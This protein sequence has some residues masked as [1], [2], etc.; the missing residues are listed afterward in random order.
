MSYTIPSDTH[1]V[2]DTGHTT[3]HNN[4]T[5]VLSGMNAASS[6]HNTAYAGGAKGDGTTDDAAAIQAAL[7]AC[8]P[9]GI[10]WL[11]AL[12]YR[13]G[14]ELTVPP[15]VT[16]AGLHGNRTDNVQLSATIKPLASFSGTGCLR[17]KDKE[18]G[19]YSADNNG[20]RVVNLVL[21][22]SATTGSVEGIRATG[23]VHGVVLD[24]VAV[25]QFASYGVG[26]H[27][28]TRLDA[29]VQHPYSW[30]LWNCMAWQNK[31]HG[32]FF[33]NQQ[34]D[35]TFLN[36][37]A[38]GNVG[39]GFYLLA[40]QN[41]QCVACRSEFNLNGFNLQGSWGTTTASGGMLI[42]GC[43]T[44]RNTQHGVRIE[45]SGNGVHTISVS[46]R[47]DGRNSN[48]GGGGF[49]GIKV[50]GAA[51][52]V[53][54]TGLS[55]YPGVDDDGSGTSS[56][57]YGLSVVNSPTFVH[58]GNAFLHA[59]VA[60]VNWDGTGTFVTRGVSTRTGST[61]SP[62]AIDF[63]GD[64]GDAGNVFGTGADGAAT[65]DGAATA[66]WASL[67]A[68]V[69]TMT[70]DAHLTALTVNNGVTLKTANFR[71][72]CQ[73]LL[74]NAGT[75]SNLGNNASGSTAGASGGSAVYTGG[76]AGGA[77]GTGVSG[78]GGAGAG[79][80]MGASAG[81]GG[82]GTSGAAGTAG[83][84]A[85]GVT[86]AIAQNNF[87]QTPYPV[88]AGAT[89]FNNAAVLFGWGAAGGGGG[90]DASSN[91]G[92]GGGG[93]GGIVPL[94]A[95]YITNTGTISANGGNGG[96]AAGG[97]AGGGG[98]GAGGLLAAFTLVPWTQ[99]GTATA[100][101]GTHGNKAGTGSNGVDGG[102][103][104]VLNVVMG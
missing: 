64:Q 36:C 33:G 93:G 44:D 95:W 69:Y 51:T 4:L 89:A 86:A 82:A 73:G 54:I 74:T 25:Q 67:A 101:G 65:L 6:V 48:S 21:D 20:I 47:R 60:G 91:A 8:P 55:C 104:L 97:N 30:N 29:S 63:Q 102:A 45:S 11:R 76:R 61:S 62:S 70:R 23:L 79:A 80:S 18:E 35:C 27:T 66:G 53:V 90:S 96:N 15:N 7:N 38:L 57:D 34:T 5:D 49:A 98:G 37:E 99:N 78:A 2:G 26:C 75:I 83:A 77:G 13:T 92:G 41:S 94:F 3:D 46:T 52:P 9:G 22:G 68:N 28:Y 24:R 88:L 31:D 58:V 39:D 85:S 100:N 103:G 12:Q 16:L 42:S 59:A 50:D 81:A 10:V 17:F 87:L 19:S 40:A 71:V 84:V 32:F 14:S 56:P 1:I 72:F 43:T